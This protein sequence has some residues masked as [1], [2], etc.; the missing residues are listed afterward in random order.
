M[1]WLCSKNCCCS[2]K[3]IGKWI[4]QQS[5]TSSQSHTK[6]KREKQ[7]QRELRAFRNHEKGYLCWSFEKTRTI[8]SC[9]SCEI[10]RNI[11]YGNLHLQFLT[12]SLSF[13]RSCCCLFAGCF[14][15]SS[16]HNNTNNNN[17]NEQTTKKMASTQHPNR[18]DGTIHITR[19]KP[20]QRLESRAV[21]EQINKNAENEKMMVVEQTTGWYESQ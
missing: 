15:S 20:T 3:T 11:P 10:F 8:R 2:L 4:Q 18:N 9:L 19:E 12:L 7:L 5:Y 21:C 6:K 16:I 17:N 1:L 14:A 13:Q